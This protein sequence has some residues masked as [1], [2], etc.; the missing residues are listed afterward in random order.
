VKAG[1]WAHI[2]LVRD[3]KAMKVTWYVNGVADRATP[4]QHRAATASNAP[5]YL[6]RGYAKHFDGLMDEVGLWKRALAPAEVAALCWNGP[7]PPRPTEK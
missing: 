3:L 4:A 6:G 1:Q 7:R 5:L 2:V